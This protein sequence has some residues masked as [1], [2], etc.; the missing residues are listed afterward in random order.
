MVNINFVPDDYIRSNESKRTNLIY[1]ILF[2]VV[3]V[4]LLGSF[5]TIKYRKK[6]LNN[7][8]RILDS[9]LALRK[10]EI[11]KVQQLQDR[12]NQMWNRA[13]ITADL[14]E[15]VSK[16]LLLASLT[17]NLPNGVS[18]L[19]LNLIQKESKGQSQYAASTAATKYQSIKDSIDEVSIE[20][21]SPEKGLETHIDIDGIAPSDL[22][23]AAYIERLGNSELITNVALIESREFEAKNSKSKSSQK[24]RHF[25]L[26][27]M[28]NNNFELKA[29]D[30]KLISND[31]V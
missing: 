19:K 28:L 30:V 21:R 11:K 9:E 4:A 18:L 5:F 3:M 17:N 26:T 8:E 6:M 13:L 7:R 29:E 31:G 20:A 25:K 27:A 12:R 24:F 2:A 14:I 15:P 23:V 16:S 10:E 22:E 1:I